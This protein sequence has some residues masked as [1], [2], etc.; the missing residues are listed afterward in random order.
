MSHSGRRHGRNGAGTI[1][2][3]MDRRIACRY[4]A[5]MKAAI[6]SLTESGSQMDHSV[7][8]EN[9][10]MQGCLVR[11]GRGPRVQPGEKV[12]LKALGDITSPVIDGIVISAVR[13]F[14]GKCTIRIRFL[15][16]LSFQTFKMLVYGTEGIDMNLKDR[17][18][19]EN[20]QFW[21]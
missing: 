17:P 18:D 19:Y 15:A 14:L 3:A 7:Q 10:S 13:P 4:P 5:A 21:R 6:L 2:S 9:V 11:S 1:S 8:L 12:W 16:P 20:D